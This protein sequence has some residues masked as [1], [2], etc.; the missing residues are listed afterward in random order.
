[1]SYR[2]EPTAQAEA[3]LNRIYERLAELDP[4]GAARW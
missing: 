1:M 3:D 2:V 4:K